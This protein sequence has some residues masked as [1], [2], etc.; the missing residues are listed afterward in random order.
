L[1]LDHVLA[2][3]LAAREAAG[4]LHLSVRSVR[5]LLARYHPEEGAAAL[6]HGNAGRVPV[7]RI[8]DQRRARLVDLATTPRW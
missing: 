4:Y 5:R 7:N 1:V 6:I 8:D 3:E 2:G